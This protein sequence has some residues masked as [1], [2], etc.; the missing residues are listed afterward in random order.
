MQVAIAIHSQSTLPAP[1][2][3]FFLSAEHAEDDLPLGRAYLS[4]IRAQR[5]FRAAGV[6]RPG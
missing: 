1:H 2:A 5:A 4:T 6:A 3:Q